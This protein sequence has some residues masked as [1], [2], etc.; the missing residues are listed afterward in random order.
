M[1]YRWVNLDSLKR[2]RN[3]ENEERV[4]QPKERWGHSC[5]AVDKSLYI[6]GGFNGIHIFHIFSKYYN[7]KFV[8]GEYLG[9]IWR[10]NFTTFSYEQIIVAEEDTFFRSN[11]TSCFYPPK[12]S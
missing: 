9:D 3:S 7:S 10:F 12:N 4:N 2:K 1:K 5:C 11:H 6:I 8:L